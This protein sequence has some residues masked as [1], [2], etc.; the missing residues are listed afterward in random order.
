MRITKVD[1]PGPATGGQKF[2]GEFGPGFL[3]LRLSFEYI[4]IDP[5]RHVLELNVQLP[6]GIFVREELGCIPINGA[7]CRVDYH[8]NFSFPAGWRGALWRLISH[9]KLQTGPLDSLS[10]LKRAAEQLYESSRG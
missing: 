9:R 1:P 10:R 7:Q 6:F 2:Y 3:H 5:V 4:K 8:C